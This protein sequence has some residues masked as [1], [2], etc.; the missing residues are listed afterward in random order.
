MVTL[1]PMTQAEYDQ[2]ADPMWEKFAHDRARNTGTSIEDERAATM[3]QRAE[4]LPQEMQTPGHRFW[5]V[6]AGDQRRVGTLWVQIRDAK[7]EA[8]IYDIE[9]DPDQRGKGYGRK[10]MAA[11]EAEVRPLGITQIALNVFGDN[12]VA[13]KLYQAMGYRAAATY[14]LKDL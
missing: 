9:M 10:A 12:A 7:H 1:R 8:Y 13:M 6:E 5:I 2:W 3:R 14:M 4:L 11:L